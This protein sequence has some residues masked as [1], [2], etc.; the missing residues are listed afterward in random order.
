MDGT[1]DDAGPR[2]AIADDFAAIR[3]RMQEIATEETVEEPEC[4]KCE[5]GGWE[6]YWT[7]GGGGPNF[8]VCPDCRNPHGHPSP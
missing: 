7:P 1:E 3:N 2:P 4:G 5:D 8:R 6:A